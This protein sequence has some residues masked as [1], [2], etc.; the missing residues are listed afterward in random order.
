[1]G[2]MQRSYTIRLLDYTTVLEDV[3]LVV[4]DLGCCSW[5]LEN[6]DGC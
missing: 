2:K 6:D 4:L 1:M 3:T 5:R